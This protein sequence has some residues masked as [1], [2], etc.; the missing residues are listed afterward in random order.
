MQAS[1]ERWIVATAVPQ[2]RGR[3]SRADGVA[4]QTIGHE[5]VRKLLPGFS[6]VVCELADAEP[7][8]LGWRAEMSGELVYEYVARDYRRH[9]IASA[10]RVFCKE[11]RRAA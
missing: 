3:L 1:D 8:L 2:I 4:W 9:G 7:I 10:M 11:Q 6:V 5:V